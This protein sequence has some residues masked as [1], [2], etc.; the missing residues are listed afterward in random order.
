MLIE[1]S[2]K[3]LQDFLEN[4]GMAVTTPKALIRQAFQADLPF[5]LIL[6]P[7]PLSP[8]SPC[9]SIPKKKGGPF[10]GVGEGNTNL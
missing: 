5:F 10:P 2:W 7:I 4:E 1:P 6:L 3:T 9:G 8:T